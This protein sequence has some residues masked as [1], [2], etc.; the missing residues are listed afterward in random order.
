MFKL[1]AAATL[2][3]GTAA[4]PATAASFDAFTSFNAVNGTNGFIYGS[5]DGSA[6]VNFVQNTSCVLV[7]VT[8][9]RGG[10]SN[11]PS[12][13]KSTGAVPS[14]GTVLLATDR[15]LVHPGQGTE[16]VFV[17][18]VVSV[19]GQYSYTAA[20]N[21]QDSNTASHSVGITEFFT[22]FGGT[23]QFFPVSVVDQNTPSLFTG[24]SDTFGVGDVFGYIVDKNGVFSNDSTGVNFA[25]TQV[26]EP[27]TWALMI[28][29]FGLVGAAARRRR[30]A[31]GL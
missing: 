17:G 27:A 25:V 28:G 20:F 12:V 24:F 14:E 9:L 26:P 30:L 1:L 15:L 19:A 8:C 5:Y 7:N 13:F 2:A 6:F 10:A 29:G 16:S 22:P 31:S 4:V 18:F 21:Q 3:L 11:L 23:T